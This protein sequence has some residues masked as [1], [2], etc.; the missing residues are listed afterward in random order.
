MHMKIQFICLKCNFVLINMQ[1][2]QREHF[3]QLIVLA[4]NDAREAKIT[5]GTKIVC[6][7]ESPRFKT[8]KIE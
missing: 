4:G 5:T 2:T 8:T 1:T 7:I 6:R 3:M